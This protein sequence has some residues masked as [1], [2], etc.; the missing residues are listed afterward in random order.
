[1]ARQDVLLCFGEDVHEWRAALAAAGLPTPSVEHAFRG[2]HAEVRGDVLCVLAGFGSAAVEAVLWELL[3]GPR[4]M[5][6]FGT[7]GGMGVS[8]THWLQPAH[9]ALQNFDG[10]P[11]PLLATMDLEQPMPIVSTDRFYGFSAL[12]EDA[13]PAEPGLSEA[14][15]RWRD[16]RVLVDMECAAF[17]HFAARFDPGVAFAAVKSVANGLDD[18]E[19]LVEGSLPALAAAARSA[20]QRLQN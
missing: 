19:S 2:C 13:Y 10:P 6:L 15:D 4:R 20:W 16:K 9:T 12:C 1:M 7:A 17:Y 3:P 5:V 18:L 8:G 14:W 11:G